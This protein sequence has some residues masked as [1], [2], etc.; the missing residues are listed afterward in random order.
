[1]HSQF[2]HQS[3]TQLYLGDYIGEFGEGYFPLSELITYLE[4]L[5]Y[6]GPVGLEVFND[7][8]NQQYCYTMAEQAM[9]A[10]TAVLNHQ[11]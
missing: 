3:T 7:I 11:G 8:Y 4:Q 6:R 5:G 10:L 1:M 2:L 9:R